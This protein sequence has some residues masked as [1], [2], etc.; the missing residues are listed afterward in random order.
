M[1]CAFSAYS[2]DMQF[3]G[4]KL[5]CRFRVVLEVTTYKSPAFPSRYTD[6]AHVASI[7]DIVEDIVISQSSR[8]TYDEC[9]IFFADEQPTDP[10]IIR[11]NSLF[12]SGHPGIHQCIHVPFGLLCNSRATG[13]VQ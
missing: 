9:A 6:S 4:P 8:H 5:S 2:C 12:P 10:V 3:H 11:E 13:R 1:H 7:V